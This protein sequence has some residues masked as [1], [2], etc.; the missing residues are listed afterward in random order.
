MTCTK[1][2]ATI[3]EKAI[4]CYRCGTP[5]A[6]PAAQRPDG[7]IRA[8]MG[9]AVALMV[10]GVL[11]GVADCLSRR[12]GASGIDGP[13]LIVLGTS[14]ARLNQ[15]APAKSGMLRGLTRRT[16]ADPRLAAM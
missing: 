16:D 12:C 3:A 7:T 2:G 11:V 9:G 6:I 1:C 4:V 14:K 10:I 8:R 15:P 5:T 13:R